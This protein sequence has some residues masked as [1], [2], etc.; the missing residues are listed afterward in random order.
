MASCSEEG[1]GRD[2]S[3]SWDFGVAKK[4]V[5]EWNLM[6]NHLLSASGG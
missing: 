5:L 2:V 6:V 3:S 4:E 1:W